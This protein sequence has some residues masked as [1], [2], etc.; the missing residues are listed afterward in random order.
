VVSDGIL[1]KADIIIFQPAPPRRT[2]A[3]KN[4]AKTSI[5]VQW[6]DAFPI[7]QHWLEVEPDLYPPRW[8]YRAFPDQAAMAALKAIVV[9]L[10]ALPSV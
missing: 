10:T 6:D 7:V 2:L 1:P 5:D 8:R 9:D 4:G 3:S